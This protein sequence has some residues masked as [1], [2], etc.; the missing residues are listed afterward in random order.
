M[1][2]KSIAQR[3][4]MSLAL[5]HPEMVSAKNRGILNMKKSQLSDFASTSEQGLSEHISMMKTQGRLKSK[6]KK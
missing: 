1:P 5:H 2:A 3:R 4:L 6:R